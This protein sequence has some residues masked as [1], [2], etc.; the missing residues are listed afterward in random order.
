VTLSALHSDEAAGFRCNKSSESSTIQH[1]HHPAPSST[2]ST[3][4]NSS[5]S[6]QQQPLALPVRLACTV[7]QNDRQDR[8]GPGPQRPLP[9]TPWYA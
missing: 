6:N 7:Q 3:S 5:N 4:S 8:R 2:S 1:K 9:F